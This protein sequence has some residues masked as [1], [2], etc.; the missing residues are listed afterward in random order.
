MADKDKDLLNEFGISEET[1]KK[2]VLEVEHAQ[3]DYRLTG[4]DENG[5]IKGTFGD[6]L[7]NEKLWKQLKENTFFG[8]DFDNTMVRIGLMNLM[9]H[10]ITQP[11]IDLKDTL[12]KKYN[13]D[14]GQ[15]LL[16]L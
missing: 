11:N 4:L 16:P 12:S 9:L 8:Y 7:T 1:Y 13:E 6:K 14:K 3:V 5:F 2:I 10:G 15:P